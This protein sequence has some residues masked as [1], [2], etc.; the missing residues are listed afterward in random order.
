MAST[1]NILFIN[2]LWR[3][4]TTYFWNKVRQN[5]NWRCYYEPLHE[6]LAV[7]EPSMNDEMKRIEVWKMLRHPVTPEGY[8]HEYPISTSGRGV[9][10]FS[11]S[12]SYERFTLGPGDEHTELESYFRFLIEHAASLGQRTC[13]QPNRMF[14]RSSWFAHR[15]PT[16]HIYISRD[17]WDVWRSMHSF[18]NKYCPSRFYLIASLNASHPM[19]GPLIEG[20]DLPSATSLSLTDAEPALTPWISNPIEVFRFFYYVYVCAS[21][22][23]CACA[24]TVVDVSA[25]PGPDEM[26]ASL[27]ACLAAEGVVAEFSDFLTPAYDRDGEF[28]A[29]QAVAEEVEQLILTRLPAIRIPE[30]RIPAYL[31]GDSP[32][33]QLLWR[34]REASGS[35]LPV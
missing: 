28:A 4:S 26:W 3:S 31:P 23:N 21:V 34:F 33:R 35:K 18:P 22:L 11:D 32:L 25:P 24:D 6:M 20:W 27:R 8:Y 2:G 12:L 9:P 7:L 14:L 30:S 17:W 10:H 29:L 16:A 13:L 1:E 15:F 19:M 5:S